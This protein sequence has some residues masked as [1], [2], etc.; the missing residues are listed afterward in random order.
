MKMRRM[1]LARY[2]AGSSVAGVILVLIPSRHE[3]A[4]FLRRLDS[5][6]TRLAGAETRVTEG[7]IGDKSV[8]VAEIG[9]GALVASRRTAETLAAFPRPAAVWLA[10]YAGGLDPALERGDV[11]ALARAPGAL[12]DASR[13]PAHRRIDKIHTSAEVVDSPAA[14]AALFKK[15]GAPVVEME[16]EAVF[17]ETDRAKLPSVAIRV[18]SD[19]AGEALPADLLAFGYDPLR[20]RETPLRMAFRLATHPRDIGRL[21]RFLAPLPAVRKTLADFLEAAV[22]A[23]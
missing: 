16:A 12:P 5:P 14:K 19:A 1:R 13:L 17:L 4:D 23:G 8:V 15:T 18:V 6:R 11:V 3:A 9:M 2:P 21:R 22:R 20:G 10:G 7:K